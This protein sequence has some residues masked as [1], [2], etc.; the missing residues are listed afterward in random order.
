MSAADKLWKICEEEGFLRQNKKETQICHAIVR[1]L[2]R[3]GLPWDGHGILIGT[4]T[5]TCV[6]THPTYNR[7]LINDNTK[8]AD[9]MAA[10]CK[11][12]DI[13]IGS[14]VHKKKA[15]EKAE[16]FRR[17]SS[18]RMANIKTMQVDGSSYL[19]ELEKAVKLYRLVK[20]V[21]LTSGSWKGSAPTQRKY[22]FNVNFKSPSE[23]LVRKYDNI[24]ILAMVADN[25]VSL[26]LLYLHRNKSIRLDPRDPTISDGVVTQLETSLFD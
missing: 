15:E 4:P 16:L 11:S 8:V 26:G 6:S 13:I 24:H 22:G 14:G 9:T 20:V 23:Y 5:P 25:H 18:L 3:G 1:Y 21:F 10:T 17:S 7:T 19:A 2:Y 12:L